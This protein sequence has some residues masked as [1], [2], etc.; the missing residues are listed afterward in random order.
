MSD[1][2]IS[3]DDSVVKHLGRIE[4]DLKNL[5]A[6]WPNQECESFLVWV[7]AERRK[8]KEIRTYTGAKT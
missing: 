5:L 4:V 2:R 6:F 7:K 3:L 1:S 8:R